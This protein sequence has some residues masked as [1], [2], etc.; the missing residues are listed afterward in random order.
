MRS[1][2]LRFSLPLMNKHKTLFR[3]IRAGR[4]V[5]PLLLL[6]FYLVSGYI[7]TKAKGIT[8]ILDYFL[9]IFNGIFFL[10]GIIFNCMNIKECII[11]GTSYLFQAVESTEPGS[12][13]DCSGAGFST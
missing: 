9:I 11:S 2:A 4:E 5:I 1:G 10:N 12:H 8:K 6:I 13:L 7:T 3:G